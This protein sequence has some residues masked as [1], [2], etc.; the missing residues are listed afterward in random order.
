MT[1]ASS[2]SSSPKS[3]LST[4]KILSSRRVLL[5]AALEGNELAIMHHSQLA[6]PIGARLSEYIHAASSGRL[7]PVDPKAV[8]F[9]V[10]GIAHYYA[11]QKYLH[12]DKPIFPCPTKP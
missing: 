2:A 4:A 11:M 5:H 3:S 6:M 10:A 12:N 9:A 1:R 7:R 8:I